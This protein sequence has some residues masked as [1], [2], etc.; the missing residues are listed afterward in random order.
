MPRVQALEDGDAEAGDGSRPRAAG[1]PGSV[2]GAARDRLRARARGARGARSRGG[3]PRARRAHGRPAWRRGRGHDRRD[4]PRR[5]RPL[6]PLPGD[7]R[8]ARPGRATRAAGSGVDLARP[9]ADGRRRARRL[10][11]RRARAPPGGDRRSRRA[12]VRAERHVRD[13]PRARAARRSAWCCRRA[14]RGCSEQPDVATAAARSGRR[15]RRRTPA[16]A[17]RSRPRPAGTRS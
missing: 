3:G 7:P 9:H 4:R 5:R 2:R 16:R 8:V 11:R 15:A 17:G 10:R 6:E 13:D 14:R 12:R 1:R